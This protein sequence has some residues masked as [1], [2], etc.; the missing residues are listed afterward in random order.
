MKLTALSSSGAGRIYPHKLPYKHGWQAGLA[1]FSLLLLMACTPQA[2]IIRDRD[3][4]DVSLP[5]SSVIGQAPPPIPLPAPRQVGTITLEETLA[6]R[7]SVRAFSDLQL[8]LEELSQLLWATQGV[9]HPD[10]YRSAPS[11]GALYPLEVYVI[12]PQGLFHY[13]PPGHNLRQ[14]QPGDLRPD[15][16]AVALRQEAVLKAPSV[17]VITAVFER[18][19]LKY[20]KERSARYVHLEAGHAAQNLLLQAV[21]LDLAAVPIGAFNDDKVKKVLSLPND[22][23]PLYLIPV[24]H[25]R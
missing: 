14:L 4:Q 7:R 21:A 24:G 20:G 3:S 1:A 22:H 10:G 6:K 19:E 8:S 11:A 25:P 16:H 5:D 18:T 9:T 13:D 17:F 12:T 2:P 23:L 15:L